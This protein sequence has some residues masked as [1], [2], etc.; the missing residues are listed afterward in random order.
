MSFN[1][2]LNVVE[3]DGFAPPTIV[4]ASVGVAAF[5][6]LTQ[7][8]VANSPVRITSFKQFADRFGGFEANALGAYLVKGFFDNGGQRAY[9]NRVV[10]ADAA[11]AEITLIGAGAADVLTLEAGWRGSPDPG[12]WANSLFVRVEPSSSVTQRLLETAPA[13]IDGAALAAPI[14]MSAFPSLSLE[15]DGEA[16]PPIT[17]GAG[18]F[19][20]AAQATLAQIRDAIN[21]RTTAVIAAVETD[22]IQLTSAGEIAARRRSW[23]SLR[24][25]ANNP[26][27]G[28]S[29]MANAVRGEVAPLAESTARLT[30]VADFQVGDAIRISEGADTHTAKLLRIDPDTQTVEWTPALADPA[31]FDPFDTRISAVEFTLAVADNGVTD[32]QIIESWP[33]LSMEPDLPNYAVTRLNDPFTGSRYLVATDA[34][35]AAVVRNTPGALAFTRLNP[36]NAGT[37]TANDFIGSQPSRTGFYAFDPFD[38]QLV[39]TERTD[40]AIV[41]EALTY[42]VR[43]GDCMFVG[44]V[45]EASVAGGGAIPYGQTF[46]GKNVFGALYGPWIQVFDPVGTGATPTRWVPPTGHVM[47]AYARIAAGRGVWKAPAGDEAALAGAL[48]VE[49]RLTDAE[50]TDLV[51]SG[52]VNGVRAIPGAGIIVDSSRTLSTDTRW[53]YVGTRLLFNFVKTSLKNGLRWVRQEP[54]RSTL[55]NTIKFGTVTPFLLGLWRQGAFGTGTPEQTFTVICDASNNPPAEVDQGNLR[56]EIYFYPSKPAETI[57]IIVGQ[58]PSGGIASEQ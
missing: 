1:I 53:L 23:T 10:A 40:A 58:Q 2:G 36:G 9:V 6:I 34:N 37:A 45:P 47:G 13:S 48:D 25:T 35:P 32:E 7:R 52:S 20:N 21:R 4:G 31:P 24:V 29:Q 18:D 33:N 30:S 54:N 41:R 39:A 17:F 15:V 57:V 38:I 28:F 55:W 27:L 8:G 46:Q 43:R 14:D 56:V 50:H 5:N 44:A 22:H 16:I 3:V 51:K 11:P 42:C 49:Y 19:A 26:T 12:A